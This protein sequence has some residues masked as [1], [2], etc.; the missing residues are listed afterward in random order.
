MPASLP[1]SARLGQSIGQFL[2][3]I[4]GGY[5]ATAATAWE[6]SK[7]SRLRRPPS[8][9]RLTSQDADLDLGTRE[10]LICKA[11]DLCRNEGIVRSVMRKYRN[12]CVGSCRIKWATGDDRIDRV[13]KNYWVNWMNMADINGIHHFTKLTK[14]AVA[15]MVRDG[16]IFTQLSDVNGFP[17]LRLI[18]ADRVTN[19]AASGGTVNRDEERIIGGVGFYADGSRKFYRVCER[20]GWGGF[21]N[22]QDIPAQD[23]VHLF[24]TDRVDG[25][26]GVTFFEAALNPSRDFKETVEAETV[27]AKKNSKWNILW[28][29]IA[30]GAGP[31][32]GITLF[33]NQQATQEGDYKMDV[34]EVDDGA[35]AY[36][37]SGEDAK[38]MESER[39]SDGWL[40]LMELDVHRVA[41]AL[42][43]PFGVVWKMAGLPG[44]GIRFDIGQAKRTFD[45]I[46]HL[47]AR[48]WIRRIAGWVIAKGAKAG[49][50]P[51]HPL[52]HSFMIARPTYITI[53]LGRDS[54]AGIEEN[55]MGLYTATEWYNETDQDFEEQTD[56]LA[57]EAAYRRRAVKRYA[58][59][60]VVLEDIRMLT[61][62]GN[63]AAGANGTD[64][65]S[66][67]RENRL[68]DIEESKAIADSYGVGVRAG[69]ITPT[70]E[71]E[72]YMRQKQG[73]PAI[74]EA[75][76]SAWQ[77][78]GGIRRPIT[79][80]AHD[81]SRPAPNANASAPAEEA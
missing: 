14:I 29:T 31:S 77:K 39:P 38:V 7:R 36:L 81:G 53:D 49:A 44:P 55:R 13:Y 2:G 41:L 51:R 59:D 46:I 3:G 70:I 15:S 37:F 42:D 33:E 65:G 8:S 43:L 47:V 50:I 22:P 52:W 78:D 80:T 66:S 63:P 34:Q 20:N 28:K 40:Q 76:R 62:N 19:V 9:D 26:R 12:Y 45:E 11:R 17:K 35:D 24:D 23:I 74:T 57:Y 30:G 60:G 75:T 56:T 21:I 71:D 73:L 58:V 6:A 61:P 72:N 1:F 32:T 67:E 5:R 27:A 18:E 79:L 25:V 48:M 64:D 16:D 69:A 10:D 54:K 4:H 68:A